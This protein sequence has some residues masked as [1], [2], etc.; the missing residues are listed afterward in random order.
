M[1]VNLQTKHDLEV[2]EDA[3][4]KGMQK[5]VLPGRVA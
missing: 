1:R 2:A 3:L 5:E 4:G